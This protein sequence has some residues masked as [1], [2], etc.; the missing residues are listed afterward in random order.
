MILYPRSWRVSVDTIDV[1]N[2]PIDFKILRTLKHAPNKAALTILNLNNDSRAQLLKRNR[3]GG[4]GGKTV[5]VAVSIE[6]G[7]AGEPWQIFAGDLRNCTSVRKDVW[8]TTLTGDDGGVQLREA[9]ISAQFTKGTS[10]AT[11]L[12]QCAKALGIGTGNIA[13]FLAAAQ[14]GD[15]AT[16]DHTMTF[17]G[18][19]SVALKRVCDS[20]GLTYSVQCGALQFLEPGKPLRQPAIR[21]TPS[22]GL[23]GSPEVSI[24]STISLGN[25]Q[26]N[27]SG[28]ATSKAKKPK[29]KATSVIKFKAA[30]IPGLVPGRIVEIDSAAFQGS[31]EITEAIYAG[32]TW[33]NV[34]EA[35][36]IARVYQ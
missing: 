4:A 23:Y 18:S 27:A 17:S 3:P 6:A 22:T 21:L 24:D 35:D 20:I 1:S 31:Y 26:S 28:T 33:A 19:A 10:I 30:L 12:Q 7:Y 32:Q 34:W 36:C 2:L 5:P 16:L 14:I 11:V 13:N 25:A 15:S 8:Q 9:T 29:A